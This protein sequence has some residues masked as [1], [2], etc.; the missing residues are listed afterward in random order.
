M[1]VPVITLNPDRF[2]SCVGIWTSACDA[3][4]TLA[5]H[6]IAP[7]VLSGPFTGR[8]LDRTRLTGAFVP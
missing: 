5:L 8:F 7:A 3:T 1:Q 6:A 4:H 2:K